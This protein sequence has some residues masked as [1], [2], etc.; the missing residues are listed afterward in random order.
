VTFANLAG[1]RYAAAVGFGKEAA[2]AAYPTVYLWGSVDGAS[3][4]H[5]MYCSRDAGAS[6]TRINDDA[7]QYG[8]PGDGQFVVGDMNAAG[9]VYMSTAGRGIVFGKPANGGGPCA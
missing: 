7:H 3:A 1:V 6:W 5:G 9:V 2:G 8:G 4:A